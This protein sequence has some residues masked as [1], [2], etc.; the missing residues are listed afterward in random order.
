MSSML[1]TIVTYILIFFQVEISHHYRRMGRKSRPKRGRDLKL[2]PRTLR[3][4]EEHQ[5]KL[6]SCEVSYH[7]GDNS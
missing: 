2:Y 6:K 4:K 7:S 5:P 1:K 3:K